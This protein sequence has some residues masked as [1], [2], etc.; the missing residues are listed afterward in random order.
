MSDFSNIRLDRINR[1]REYSLYIGL[2]SIFM[3]FSALISAYVVRQAAGN[4]LEFPL[5]TEFYVSTLLILL[6]SIS[7]FFSRKAFISNNQQ[8]Y[9]VLL[10]IS[11]ILGL[12]FVYYQ[13]RGWIEMTN[14]G[15]FMDGNPSGSFVY[16]ISGLHAL[17][18]LGGIL[19]LI[20]AMVDSFV[21]KQIVVQS[22]LVRLN[23]ITRYW[24]FVDILWLYL[25]FFMLVT[26]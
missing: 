24:H 11:L 17:H 12:S 25:F 9:R 6:S 14:L 19:A 21:N 15:V 23:I 16:I 20:V 7:L 8:R 4:W 10:I 26:R 1:A 2:A 18:V 13:Y 5:P 22:R 3:M